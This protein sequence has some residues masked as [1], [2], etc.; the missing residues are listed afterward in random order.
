MTGEDADA[1]S[2]SFYIREA[3][4]P[5]NSNWMRRLMAAKPNVKLNEITMPGS[6]DAG[7]Y[8]DNSSKV[9]TGLAHEGAG[10]WAVTQSQ[11]IRNQLRAGARYFDLRIYYDNNKVQWAF[12]GQFK[13][14]IF[15]GGFGGKFETILEDIFNFF[16][17]VDS[18][19]AKPE[20]VVIL[21]IKPYVGAANLRA[22]IDL[23]ET[24]L[25]SYLYKN[26]QGTVPD[27][28]NTELEDLKGKVIVTYDSAFYSLIRAED[29]GFPNYNCGN[30]K[31]GGLLPIPGGAFVVYDVYSDANGFAAMEKDQTDKLNR[32]AG[33][34]NPYL[35]LLSWTLTGHTGGILDLEL[36]SR[37]ANPQLA[38]A[39]HKLQVGKLPNIVYL[40]YVNGYLCSAIIALNYR[41]AQIPSAQ[42]VPGSGVPVLA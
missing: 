7:M 15:Y 27:F 30:Q 34:G 36:L 10:E 22:T 4:A 9:A 42:P 33:Y 19:G 23:V 35:F 11:N 13:G 2:N 26:P 28:G 40:D 39:L 3:S 37:M 32:Y 16:D 8:V 24:K 5:D 41:P 12:H 14:A 31:T 6:H 25:G 29:G 38:K 17:R 18:T 20:E 21:Q 1:Y